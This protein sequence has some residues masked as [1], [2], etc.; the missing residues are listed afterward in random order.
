MVLPG[1]PFKIYVKSVKGSFCYDRT[2]K[3]TYINILAQRCPGFSPRLP[4]LV[5]KL[6]FFPLKVDPLQALI[7]CVVKT[8]KYQTGKLPEIV[9]KNEKMFKHFFKCVQL[10]AYDCR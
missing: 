2:S 5:R 10:A 9:G 6:R 8:R 1:S 3:H 4:A 7:E